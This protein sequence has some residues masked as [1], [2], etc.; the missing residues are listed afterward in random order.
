MRV[1]YPRTAHLP[2]SP[3]ATADDVRA[4]DLSGL[5]GRYVVVTEKMD[6]E[7]TT[8]YRDGLHARSLDSAHHPSRA[9]VKALHSRI[10]ARIPEGWRISGE[11]LFARHSISYGDLDGYFYGFSVWDGDQCLDWTSTVAF[12]QDLGIPTPRVLWAGPFDEKLI[13][14]QLKLD[15]TRQ[16][17]YVVRAAEGFAYS[18]FAERVAKW[19][20]PSHVQTDKHWMH[21]EVVPNQL[22]AKAPFWAVRSGVDVRAEDL[23]TALSVEPVEQDDLLFDAYSRLDAANCY[24]NTRLVGATASLLHSRPRAA[25]MA[26]LAASLEMPTVRRIADAVGLAPRLHTSIDDEYRRAGLA[27]MSFGTDLAMLHSVA[28]ATASDSAAMENVTWSLLFA[29]DC[30]LLPGSPIQGLRSACRDA[31]AE[32]SPLAADRCWG[33]ARLLFAEGRISSAEEAAA[34]TW[35]WR[36][37]DFPRLLHLVGVSGSGK[38]STAS[39]LAGRANTD[40]DSTVLVSLDDLRTARGSRADQ[41]A[42]QEVLSAGLRLLDE[43]LARGADVVWDATSLT[44]QQRGLVDGAARRRNALIDHRVHLAPAAVLEERN[45]QRANPVP[46]NVLT[47]QVRRFDPPYPG[48][49]HR[50]T[51][52]DTVDGDASFDCDASFDSLA[53]SI[54]EG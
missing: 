14:K 40:T 22:G 10:A 45:A 41:S 47:A 19:V 37:G 28:A 26:D 35:R 4:R 51:Y 23:T 24:G 15:L 20:R 32:L 33:E 17:G 8:L 52:V 12:F 48:E 7:N 53:Y 27:R 3:G 34:A 49:A 29:E 18:E 46:A 11:N 6:G 9:W 38:S 50:A 36:D 1:H 43:A 2:W 5:E 25:L 39:A 16:E 31:F 54:W 42:N 13:R 44:R 21:A 30:G